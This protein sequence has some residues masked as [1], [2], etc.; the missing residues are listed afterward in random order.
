MPGRARGANIVAAFLDLGFPM[1]ISLLLPP[2]MTGTTFAIVGAASCVGGFVTG[3]FGIGGGVMFLAVLAQFLPPTV[4]IPVHGV[5]MVGVNFSRA[6]ISW[7]DIVWTTMPPYVIGTLIG[8]V[9]GGLLFVQI[10]PWLIQL[11]IGGFIL[12]TLFGRM[13]VIDGRKVALTGAIASFLTMFFGATGNFIAAIVKSMN[14]HPVS[15]VATHST[16]MGVQSALKVTTFAVLG[17]AYAPYLPFAGAMI[18]AGFVGT[19]LA[20]LFLV[21]WGSRYF[22]PL[23]TAVL[24]VLAA[25]LVWAG[26]KGLLVN[27]GL[28]A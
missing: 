5:C 13:P 10:P 24:A 16:M 1:D 26:A 15:H 21:R 11:V 19:F 17:F 3:A 20:K 18:V 9:M 23:L 4:L 6:A 14:L 12:W 25:R 7:R 8:A 27:L 2:D 22:K 28:I